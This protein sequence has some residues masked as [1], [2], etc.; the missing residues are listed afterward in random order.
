MHPD[1]PRGATGFRPHL[2]RQQTL[3]SVPQALTRSLDTS[4]SALA[5]NRFTRM[6][7]AHRIRALAGFFAKDSELPAEWANYFANFDLIVSYLFDPD[8]IF[9]TNLKR[10]GVRFYLA[11]PS[12]LD[13]SEHAALQLA[14]PLAAVDLHLSSPAARLFPS[15]GRCLVASFGKPLVLHRGQS[16]QNKNGRRDG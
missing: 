7:F 10:A 3:A 16:Q 8:G 14:R 11:G 1:H 5:E 13:N 12:K 2:A 9:E 4:T 6:R 15:D